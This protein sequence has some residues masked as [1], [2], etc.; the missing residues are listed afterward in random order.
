MEGNLMFG[1]VFDLDGVQGPC[2]KRREESSKGKPWER[3]SY[4]SR[5]FRLIYDATTSR[6]S[7]A[8][9]HDSPSLGFLDLVSRSC[10]VL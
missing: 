2:S 9:I 5:S 3:T 10:S 1:E 4:C 8:L 7:I 6:K